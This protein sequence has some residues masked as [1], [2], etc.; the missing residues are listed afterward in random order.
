MYQLRHVPII[1]FW[2]R[3]ISQDNQS[4]FF[5]C[6]P[7]MDSPRMEIDRP[8]VHAFDLIGRHLALLWP[9]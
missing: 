1:G 7:S 5:I 4:S 6:F 9:G 2:F 8:V 3:S